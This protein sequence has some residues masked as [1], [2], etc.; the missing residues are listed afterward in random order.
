VTSGVGINPNPKRIGKKIEKIEKMKRLWQELLAAVHGAQGIAEKCFLLFLFVLETVDEVLYS[1]K[2]NTAGKAHT[3]PHCSCKT[4]RSVHV[5][6]QNQ[7]PQIEAG[8]EDS[9]KTRRA[10]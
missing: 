5:C 9:N 7:C 8:V 6:V 2:G 4:G 10:E 1:V 3:K